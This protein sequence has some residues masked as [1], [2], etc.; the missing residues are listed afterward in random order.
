[1]RG[2][3][4]DEFHKQPMLIKLPLPE[5]TMTNTT[6]WV[7]NISWTTY[8]K[9]ELSINIAKLSYILPM[10]SVHVFNYFRCTVSKWIRWSL[11]IFQG[12]YY[13]TWLIEGERHNKFKNPK[14][15]KTPVF[16]SQDICFSRN[17]QY[18]PHHNPMNEGYFQSSWYGNNLHPLTLHQI[19]SPKHLLVSVQSFNAL[20]FKFIYAIC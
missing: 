15:M 13:S 19:V 7:N 5:T 2:I 10:I 9:V 11:L 8:H 17:F 1:M 14:R 18:L 6:T 20:P 4:S 16:R 3:T 12:W